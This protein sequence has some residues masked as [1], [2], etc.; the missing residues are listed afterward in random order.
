MKGVRS[1]DVGCP[2]LPAGSII[3]L[4]LLEDL[5]NNLCRERVDEAVWKLVPIGLHELHHVLVRIRDDETRAEDVDDGAEREVPGTVEL[6]R[7]CGASWFCYSEIH[8]ETQP[9]S[10]T[11]TIEASLPIRLFFMQDCA[12]MDLESPYHF[13]PA[14]RLSTASALGWPQRGT[15]RLST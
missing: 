3:N 2:T 14:N 4:L 1:L 9:P 7:L 5:L 15:T 10:T 11:A 12:C 13:L 6:G 8:Q